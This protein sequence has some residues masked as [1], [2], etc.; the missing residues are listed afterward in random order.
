MF[1]LR[2]WHSLNKVPAIEITTDAAQAIIIDSKL[3]GSD[4]NATAIHAKQGTV[5]VRNTIT[6]G[7]KN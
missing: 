5:F 3:E 6:S 4:K 1:N 2:K 7:Y